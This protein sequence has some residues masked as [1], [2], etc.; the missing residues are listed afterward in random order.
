V[1]HI[2]TLVFDG[3]NRFHIEERPVPEPGPGDVRVRVAFTGICG[4]DLHGY[5]GESGRRTPGMVMGHEASGWVEAVGRDVD[6]LAIGTPVTF[7]PVLACGGSC[8]HAVENRCAELQV[9]GVAADIQGAFADAIVVPA[10]RVVALGSLSLD[11]GACVEPMAVGLQAVHRAG[12]AA[13]QSALVVGGGMIGQCIARAARLVGAGSVSISESHPIRRSQAVAGGFRGIA[14]DDV[15]AEGPFDVAFDAVGISTTAAAAIKSVRKG[16]TV[17]FVGL[18]LPTISIPLFDV[19]VAERN[20]VGTFCYT[21]A[22]FEES[23]SHLRDGSL[24][25]AS[26]IGGVESFDDIHRAFEALATQERSD[27][28]VLMA[29]GASGPIVV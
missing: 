8:G 25:V 14:P 21:D 16:A 17:C 24:E 11:L 5:T 28:K 18:G 27:A 29:T 13:G 12:V 22:V 7:N 9:I 10:S 2:R 20:I 6:G 1:D 19:V 15:D 4:S 23:A 3:P 26:L